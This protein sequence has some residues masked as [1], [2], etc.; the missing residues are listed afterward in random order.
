MN[1]SIL[2]L[3]VVTVAIAL[4][5]VCQKQYNKNTAN[6]GAF[7]FSAV[8]VLVSLALFFI[9][10]DKPLHFESGV[11]P[12]SFGFA[13]SYASAVIFSVLAMRIGPMAITMLITSF[14]LFIP[15]FYGIVFLKEPLSAFFCVGIVLL[16]VS[17]VLVNL[18]SDKGQKTSVRWVVYLFLAFFGNGMCS[19]FQNMQV[20]AYEGALKSEFMIAALVMA[21][22][23]MFAAAFAGDRKEIP[24]V[25]R[26]GAP[27]AMGY[28]LFNAVVNLLVIELLRAGELPTSMIFPCISAGSMVLAFLVSVFLYKEKM[29]VKQITGFFIGIAAIVFLNI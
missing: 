14:S 29:S 22:V 16:V 4:Q 18:K 24:T 19:T 3:A 10:A 20:R 15:T 2:W 5:G 28:G 1:M 12:Y 26:R 11:L 27:I 13:A 8:A 25:L 9:T 7:T 17:L 6:R 21:A 23:I